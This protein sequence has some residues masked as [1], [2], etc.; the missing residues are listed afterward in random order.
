MA[1]KTAIELLRALATK[2]GGKEVKNIF[3][4]N[5]DDTF[6]K[7]EV[8]EGIRIITDREKNPELAKMFFR[9]NESLEDD[10]VNLL[11]TRYMG[12]ERLMAHPFSFN[13]RGPGAADRYKKIN[14]SGMRLTD[15]PGGPA[16]KNLYAKH[17]GEMKD[18]EFSG[19]R[20]YKNKRPTILDEADDDLPFGKSGEA[21]EFIK[22]Q[23]KLPFGKSGEASRFTGRSASV[24][25][26]M[27][28]M[29]DTKAIEDSLYDTS[30]ADI[31]LINRM[32][33][34]TGKSETEVREAL[35]D[36][37]NE[38]Y[39]SGSSKLMKMNDDDRLRAYISNKQ[40]VP[41]ETEQ[42][43]DDMME[44][45]DYTKPV[46]TGDEIL[47]NMRKMEAEVTAMKEIAEAE[48]MQYGQGMDAFR[49]MLDDGEDPAE[50]LEFLKSVFNR[51]KQAKGGRVDMAL[52]GAATGI[53]Q[54]IKL[55]ARGIK[56]FGQK[57]TY[58]QNV[59]S[60]GLS[61]EQFNKVLKK[62][63][64]GVPDE[65]VDEPTG[66]GLKFSLDEAEDILTGVKFGLLTQAQRTKI[67]KA[68]RDKVAKQ[69]YDEPVPG[70]NNEYF[71]YMDDAIGR[72][73][74]LLEIERLGG[75]LTPK[76][77]KGAPEFIQ[78]DFTQLNRLR[79]QGKNNVIPF[80]PR[81]KKF[82]GGIAG[83]LKRIMSP[84]LEKELV[85]KGPFQT[86]HRADIIGD[87]EQIKN[88]SRSDKSSLDDMDYLYDMVQQ[89]PRYNEAMRGAMM[90]LVDYE[91]FRAILL[92]DN[93]K[94]QRMLKIDPEGS[95]EFIRRLFRAG[96]SQPQFSTGGIV[97]TLA[98]PQSDKAYRN[99]LTNEDLFN[100]QSQRE[101]RE[102]DPRDS[103]INS[104][105]KVP[106]R[107]GYSVPVTQTSDS[108]ERPLPSLENQMG[109]LPI[110]QERAEFL[111]TPTGQGFTQLDQSIN[112]LGQALGQ[113]QQQIQEQM[114]Q[115]NSGQRPIS[116]LQ[117]QNV[118]NLGGL[119]NLFGTRS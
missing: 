38:G 111:Q 119:G 19:R 48:Q 5:L 17:F 92:E 42:F 47:A 16:D 77:V 53:M 69:I 107:P 8:R 51:T 71:E 115:M 32:M 110:N 79:D 62:Q 22:N 99:S 15:L 41:R 86:G 3:R 108:F 61:D 46:D 95:E 114:A 105:S 21:E 36:M 59:K 100:M 35:V 90:K 14:D 88:V 64:D 4:Q 97:N 26:Q 57:Q 65:V 93:D 118:L 55:A 12:S 85:E 109:Q 20:V 43:V 94:L 39:E 25:K 50:A 66:R 1:A 116:S 23:D 33:K 104:L 78:P 106:I 87:M 63:L 60:M 6:G 45:L 30:I 74:D 28:D 31:P 89:S 7:D 112:N 56:P 13:R 82:K 10:L 84:K 52:G 34:Q 40:A 83:L 96:G 37:A 68:M 81:E 67:A 11:E 70:L 18:T 54:A 98:A 49:R 75:D 117:S 27:D 101:Q 2:V 102:I 113:G 103:I 76:P 91:R 24:Q 58:K 73:D 72:M 44:R 29:L 80:K 9:E